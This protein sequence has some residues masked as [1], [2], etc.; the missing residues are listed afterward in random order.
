MPTLLRTI[1]WAGVVATVVMLLLSREDLSGS[2]GLTIVVVA[3]GGAVGS[4][5]TL[6]WMAIVIEEMRAIRRTLERASSVEAS[7]SVLVP[8]QVVP[9]R[10]FFDPALKNVMPGAAGAPVVRPGQV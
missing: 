2:L 6:Y 7:P 5:I 1:G 4:L 8:Q 3:I 10:P 9:N